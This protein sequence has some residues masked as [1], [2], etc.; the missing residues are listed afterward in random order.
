MTLPDNIQLPLKDELIAQGGKPLVNYMQELTRTLQTQ[1]EENARAINGSF[2]QSEL[3]GSQKWVPKLID[4]ADTDITFTYDHQS[5]MVWRR[6]NMVDLWFDVK[7]SAASAALTGNMYVELPYKVININNKPFVGIC[8]PSVF[9]YTGGTDCVVNAI[10][11]S[12]RLEVWNTGNGFTSANQLSVTA[13]HLI[14][15]I[16]YVGQTEERN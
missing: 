2:R 10:P 1:Y 16:R 12:Y 7:W 9:A 14:G 3:S 15:S 13:G 8:Q 6:R 5:G 11:D 4:S